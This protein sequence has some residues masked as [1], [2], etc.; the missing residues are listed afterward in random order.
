MTIIMGSREARQKFAD[1][2]GRVG[3][4]KETA[5]VERSGKPLVALVPIE[6]YEKLIAERETRFQVLD[7]IRDSLPETPEQEIAQ[8]VEQAIAVVRRRNAARGD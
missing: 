6:V 5:I 1:L 3:Y 4:G 8:D 2:I 7:R